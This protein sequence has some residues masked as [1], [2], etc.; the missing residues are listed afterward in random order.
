[1][2]ISIFLGLNQEVVHK[3]NILEKNQDEIFLEQ[4]PYLLDEYEYSEYQSLLCQ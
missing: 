4:L 1:M 3:V 2:S